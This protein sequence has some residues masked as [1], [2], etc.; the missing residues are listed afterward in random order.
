MKAVRSV[1]TTGID[2]L[3]PDIAG[4]AIARSSSKPSDLRFA[5][6]SFRVT[7]A[8]MS[9]DDA[10]LHDGY[11][12]GIEAARARLGESHPLMIEARHIRVTASTRSDPR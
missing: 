3:G 4:D 1:Q 10:D 9:A 12:R 6:M 5:A 7:Y 8:T 2:R 11:D